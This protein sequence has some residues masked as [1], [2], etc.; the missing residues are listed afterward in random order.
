MNESDATGTSCAVRRSLGGGL[1]ASAVSEVRQMS[2]CCCPRRFG[3][4][5]ARRTSALQMHTVH[6]SAPN[7]AHAG[8]PALRPCRSAAT[9]ATARGP[10]AATA[11]RCVRG[12]HPCV[13]TVHPLRLKAAFRV[14]ES[15]LMSTQVLVTGVPRAAGS[16][17]GQPYVSSLQVAHIAAT[18]F[19]MP[20]EPKPDMSTTP[21]RPR[22]AL[23]LQG[24]VFSRVNIAATP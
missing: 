11:S 24:F 8:T 20:L 16:L 12:T 2:G 7:N 17:S 6:L 14:D 10:T 3:G 19:A 5:K 13:H 23:Q 15:L 4:F 21:P 1:G 22:S 9:P 18:L